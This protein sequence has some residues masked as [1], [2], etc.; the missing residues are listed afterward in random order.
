M[1]KSSTI[2]SYFTEEVVPLLNDFFAAGFDDFYNITQSTFRNTGVVVTQIAFSSTS[3]PYLHGVSVRS[4]LTD[5][6]MDRL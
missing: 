3:N 4:T 2:I 6:N 1:R 5:V